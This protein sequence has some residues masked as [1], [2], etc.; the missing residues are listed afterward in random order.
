MP[1]KAA[2]LDDREGRTAYKRSCHHWITDL[3]GA[4]GQDRLAQSHAAG[5][6]PSA[7]GRGSRPGVVPVDLLDIYDVRPL[8]DPEMHR[9]PGAN[10]QIDEVRKAGVAQTVRL[11]VHDAAAELEH[12]HREAVAPAMPFDAALAA[13]VA[14]QPE[15]RGLR[16]SGH[17]RDLAHSELG[18]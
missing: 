2:R 12:A 10:V 5:R 3:G 11:L 17:P 1:G 18:A 6:H 4:E 8:E 13:E 14:E 15:C 9:L 7:D 16:Q